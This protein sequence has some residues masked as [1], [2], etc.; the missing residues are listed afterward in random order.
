[1][2]AAL[3]ELP[4]LSCPVCHHPVAPQT[5]D[6]KCPLCKEARNPRND[7]TQLLRMRR[8]LSLQLEESSRLQVERSS[9]LRR[10]EAQL[11]VHQRQLDAARQQYER[12]QESIDPAIDASIGTVYR[13][14]GYLQGVVED[15]ERQ[16]RMVEELEAARARRVELEAQIERLQTEL[17]LAEQA[18][19]ERRENARQLVA[20]N[21]VDLLHQDER[22]SDGNPVEEAFATASSVDFSF[23]DNRVLV[24]GRRT[25]SASS[26]V[27]LK[28]SF[29]LAILIASLRDPAFRYPR[30]LIMDNIE[31]KGMRPS[32]SHNFQH[33]LKSV[34]QSADV[35]HQ[36]IATTSMISDE[37]KDTDV[38]VG[39][40]YTP[41]QKSL[42]MP[43][44]K[45]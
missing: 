9:T 39:R 29:H 12:L 28:N 35:E 33:L 6:I 22:Y 23:E 7:K 11:P 34:S 1:M 31:D 38:V 14:A 42:R 15:L 20:D 24:D 30:L 2:R 27:V 40:Y 5:D 19:V 18:T 44:S 10:I 37:L 36:I 4:I 32:R 3:G 26:M 45:T 17:N 21:T 13:E 43:P 25:F 41:T 8:E 16:L